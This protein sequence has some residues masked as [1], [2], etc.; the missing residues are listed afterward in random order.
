MIYTGFCMWVCSACNLLRLRS[1]GWVAI[2][3]RI[4]DRGSPCLTPVLGKMGWDRFEFVI[5]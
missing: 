5:I 4:P 3:K 1:M 2:A